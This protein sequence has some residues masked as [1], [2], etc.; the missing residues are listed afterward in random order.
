MVSLPSTFGELTEYVFQQLPRAQRVDFVTDSYHPHSIKE[1]ERSIRCSSKAHLVGK[2]SCVMK[3][4][5]GA[6]AAS[7]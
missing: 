2:S 7:S 4:T 5:K 6:C 1:L 3:K